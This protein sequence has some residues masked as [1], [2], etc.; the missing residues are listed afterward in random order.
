M[1]SHKTLLYLGTFFIL[2]DIT[3]N[4]PSYSV[5]YFGIFLVL[6]GYFKWKIYGFIMFFI[7]V[8]ITIEIIY[9]VFRLG[10]RF[11]KNLAVKTSNDPESE[12]D[13]ESD[14]DESEDA[15]QSLVI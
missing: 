10:Y 2:F 1:A 13:S 14:S 9:D 5:S 4:F 6:I 12:S 11:F 8:C 3:M 15:N 7:W